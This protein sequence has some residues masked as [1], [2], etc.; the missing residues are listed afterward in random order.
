[1]RNDPRT[2]R[3]PTLGVV[4]VVLG[5]CGRI[6]YDLLDVDSDASSGGT[7]THEEIY[8]E[9]ETGSLEAPFRIIFDSTASGSY[10]VIDDDPQPGVQTGG[11]ATYQ[12][13]VSRAGTYRI[14]GRTRRSTTDG[15][16]FLSINDSERVVYDATEDAPS[17]DWRWTP[18]TG[19]TSS[20]LGFELD[21]GT[22]QLVFASRASQSILDAFVLTTNPDFDL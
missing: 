5:G 14:W 20:P 17:S 7:D 15:S 11:S 9:A 16:F 12:V 8:V 2:Q 6:G 4:L 10:Y 13:E 22:H 19:G 21:V 1:M 18:V 3:S